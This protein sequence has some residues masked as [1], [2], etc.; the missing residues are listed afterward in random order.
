[1]TL[2]ISEIKKEKKYNCKSIEAIAK[3]TVKNLNK[4]QI[5]KIQKIENRGMNKCQAG[6]NKWLA[7]MG[8]EN[9]FLVIYYLF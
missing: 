2:R 8:L 1:M 6:K 9:D 7:H 4:F 5:H 3:I